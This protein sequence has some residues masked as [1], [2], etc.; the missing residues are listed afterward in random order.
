M[1][2]WSKLTG[3]IAQKFSELQKMNEQVLQNIV[4]HDPEKVGELIKDNKELRDALKNKDL[5]A[6]QK[7]QSKY[8]HYNK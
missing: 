7:I 8:A 3:E 2:D 1:N 6:I 5:N 4:D